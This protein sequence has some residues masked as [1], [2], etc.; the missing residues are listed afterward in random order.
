MCAAGRRK[1]KSGGGTPGRFGARTGG[2]I[3]KW[4][5]V[6]AGAGGPVE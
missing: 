6:I 4:N 5:K 2:E 1:V 3:V